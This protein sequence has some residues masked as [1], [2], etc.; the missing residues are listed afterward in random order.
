MKHLVNFL[1]VLA[2]LGNQIWF[3][4]SSISSAAIQPA[5]Q[6]NV[7][8]TT[9]PTP[10]P[11]EPPI[12]GA[13]PPPVTST[14][15]IPPTPVV[16]QTPVPAEIPPVT[17]PSD[18][19]PQGIQLFAE[20]AIYIEGKPITL[21]LNINLTQ[22]KAAKVGMAIKVPDGIH[23]TDKSLDAAIDGNHLL[24]ILVNAGEDSAYSFSWIVDDAVIKPPFEFAVTLTQDD[25]EI[26]DYNSVVIGAGQYQ[27]DSGIGKLNTI[28][29][30]NNA[31]NLT[32]PGEAIDNLLAFDVRSPSL[33]KMPSFTLSG[34]P[35]EIIAVDTVTAKNVTSFKKPL[36]LTMKYD[37]EAFQGHNEENLSLFYFN[38]SLRDWYPIN[39][40]VDTKSKT[41]TAQTDHL[42]VFDY[43]INDWQFRNLPSVD[44]FQVSDFT[45]AGTYSMGLWTP[46]GTAGFQP[47]L[48]LSYN[49]QVVD[50]SRAFTQA[51]WVGMGWSLDTPAITV[52]FHETESNTNDDTFYL[53]S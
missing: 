3:Q 19:T 10:T 39:T 50:E 46:P 41:L 14:P 12:S 42:T 30:A 38:E 34:N 24:N 17:P 11:T 53:S 2:V 7:V 47:N 22:S 35:I 48:T 15:T 9:T 36:T 18:S 43:N 32:V 33:N 5:S 44:T 8:A 31:V 13:Y 52:N 37:P 4:A 16:T 51:S 26:I 23:S 27:A 29:T 28:S 25:G 21:T 20:P 1:L 45:G 40:I 49:S 6:I